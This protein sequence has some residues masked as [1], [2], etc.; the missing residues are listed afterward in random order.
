MP[1]IRNLKEDFLEGR[2][3]NLRTVTYAESGT[4]DPFVTKDLENPPENRGLLLQVNK[5]VDDL[6]RISKLLI[7]KPGLKFAANEAL[8]KQSELTK[9]LEGNNKKQ[10]G[11]IIRR[12]GGTAKHVT[13]V[14]GSTLAQVPVNGTGTHFVRGFRVDTYLQDNEPTTGFADFFGAGGIEGSQ[15]ALKG[16]P[17]PSRG[18]LTDS[19]LPNNT[20]VLPGDLGVQ[21]QAITGSLGKG[22]NYSSTFDSEKPYYQKTN[23][24]HIG[25]TRNGIT[26]AGTE[27]PYIQTT[28][29]PF[30]I[31]VK[32]SDTGIVDSQGGERNENPALITNTFRPNDNKEFFQKTETNILSTK[33]GNPISRGETITVPAGTTGGTTQVFTPFPPFTTV[34][35]GSFGISNKIGFTNVVSGSVAGLAPAIIEKFNSGSRKTKLSTGENIIAVSSTGVIPLDKAGIE[36]TN[37]IVLSQTNDFDSGNVVNLLTDKEPNTPFVTNKFSDSIPYI[38]RF[39]TNRTSTLDNIN[40]IQIQ[41]IGDGSSRTSQVVGTDGVLPLRDVLNDPLGLRSISLNDNTVTSASYD[42]LNSSLGGDQPLGALE[43]FRSKG[44]VEDIPESTTDFTGES[45]RPVKTYAFDYNNI[46]I[47][48]ETR[49]G[50][51]NPGKISRN[52]ISYFEQD[53]DTRDKINMIDV[54]E[55]PLDGI[56]ENRDLIQ[57]EFQVLTPEK[58]F[59]LAFRAFLDS[60]DDSFDASWNNTQYLGRADNFYT[61]TGFERSINIGFKIAAQTREEMEPLYRKAATLAS[62]TAPTYGEKGRFMRGSLA[63]V[64]VGD[65]IFEQPGIIDSVQYSWQTDYPWEISFQNPE[66]GDKKGDQILPHVLDVS[67]SFKVIHDFTP[68]TGKTPFITNYRPK[69]ENKRVYIPLVDK[70]VTPTENT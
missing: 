21:T 2:M 60:F 22:L 50:L 56:E 16:Q 23:T 27:K 10:V 61:Y 66:I 43:D 46:N 42:G 26:F 6:T 53:V 67:V 5:R 48:K 55:E 17:V 40:K 44:Q 59:Y 9:K 30:S 39:Q 51:G 69:K 4:Q 29:V 62:V 64:T 47:N 25:I 28:N 3:D 38:G 36:T 33:A 45:L 12:V 15:F 8:L 1:I 34:R 32:K 68:T 35:S 13:Q 20:T 63:K 41:G 18:L 49:V 57:L 70:P 24:A 54:K 52:R 11:N 19:I 65:Y 14:V 7:N 58:T 37:T 31:G